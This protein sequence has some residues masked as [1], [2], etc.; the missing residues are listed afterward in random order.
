MKQKLIIIALS[1]AVASPF[2]A[3]AET[4]SLGETVVT[5]TRMSQPLDQTI[6]HTTV[7]NEREIRKSGAPDVP[8]LLRSLSGM[9]VV[10]S[11]GLGKVSSIYMRGANSSHVLVLLDGVRINSATTGTTAI[12]HIMLDSIE[13]IE[14]VRGN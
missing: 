7:L 10:Q 11:G 13:R 4:P 5:A 1:G 8:A 2:A 6:A 12:E 14:V 9:E 3:Y